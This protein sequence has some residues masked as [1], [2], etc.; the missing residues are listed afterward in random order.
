MQAIE[1]VDQFH[2]AMSMIAA[3]ENPA[4]ADFKR[5][6]QV[7]RAVADILVLIQRDMT[8]RQGPARILPLADVDARLFVKAQQRPILRRMSI[9]PTNPSTFRSKFRVSRRQPVVPAP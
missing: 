1:K 2:R 9:Q 6:Q 5:G 4:A 7:E 3:S 8:G